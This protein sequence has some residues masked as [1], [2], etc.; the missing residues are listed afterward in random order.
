MSHSGRF[1]ATQMACPDTA[2]VERRFQSALKGTSHWRIVGDRLELYGATG[3]PLAV[4]ERGPLAVPPSTV[5]SA[6]RGTS[7]QLVKFQ[8]GDGTTLT[9]DD[10][11]KYTLDFGV[12]VVSPCVSTV[13]AAAAH[14][15]RPTQ[16]NWS[17]VRWR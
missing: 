11:S 9:P 15:K 16:V 13:T 8:G 12:M 2:D 4:F 17:S 3:K 10:R 1:A 14:G 6:L 7:W 5:S